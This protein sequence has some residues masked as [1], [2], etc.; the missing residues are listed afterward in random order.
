MRKT[1]L[2]VLLVAAGC[3]SSADG[4][5]APPEGPEVSLKLGAVLARTGATA[6]PNWEAAANLATSD[7]N[8]ALA[9]V[10]Y[11]NLKFEVPVSD[12]TGTPAVT[13]MRAQ[14]LLAGGAK[15]L[16]L[17]GSEPTIAV[18]MLN[19]DPDPTKRIQTTLVCQSCGSGSMN[20]PESKDQDPQRQATLRDEDRWLFKSMMD[21]GLQ[22]VGVARLFLTRGNG[23]DINGDGKVKI[24]VFSN[25]DAFGRSVVSGLRTA[26]ATQGTAVIIDAVLAPAGA[27]PASYDYASDIAQ[28][29]DDS[30]NASGGPIKDGFP[31]AVFDGATVM[32]AVGFTRV[33]RLSGYTIPLYHS[34]SFRRLPAVE[35]IGDLANG[36]EGV[37][38]VVHDNTPSGNTFAAEWQRISTSQLFTHDPSAYDGMA[39]LMLATL[40]ASKDMPDPTLV[41][42]RAIR[43]ALLTINTPN[44]LR[45][46]TGPGEFG[47]AVAAISAGR[48]INYDGAVGSCDFDQNRKTRTKMARWRVEKRIFRD[49]EYFDCATD[50][51]C[52]P[53]P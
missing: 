8:A 25:D 9:L 42:S 14:E 47:R 6:N 15:A 29:I 33:Y 34:N 51:T 13:V 11:R 23:G 10:K 2:V 53:I 18:N 43:D 28:L 7:M 32:Y 46:G 19:Y 39:M 44:G 27:D 52:P 49:V 30:T 5:N 36:E 31:D 24:A 45:V 37:S 26:F 1:A 48:P 16:L 38:T 40:V 21:Q 3:G 17:D 20:N 12:S 22:T 4:V 35:A 41:S 50:V